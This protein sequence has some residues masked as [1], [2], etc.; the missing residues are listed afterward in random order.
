LRWSGDHVTAIRDFAHARYALE[1]A[2]IIE[3]M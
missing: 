2:D 1:G 3:T